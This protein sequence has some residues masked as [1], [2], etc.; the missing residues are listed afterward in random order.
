MAVYPFLT[1]NG[2]CAEAMHFYQSCFGGELHLSYLQDAPG[3]RELPREMAHLIVN[4]TLV[5]DDI[6]L[7]A[8]D[9][10]DDEGI[11]SGNRIS[12]LFSSSQAEWLTAL[13]NKLSVKG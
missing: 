4:A 13:F 6:R 9:L 3:L 8:S 7:F 11:Y 12:L 5:A 2:N 1:F 10:S